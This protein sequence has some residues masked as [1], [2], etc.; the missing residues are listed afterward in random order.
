[1][2]KA[3][4][5]SKDDFDLIG[6]YLTQLQCL[7][8]RWENE[9][10]IKEAFADD[11]IARYDDKILSLRSQALSAARKRQELKQRERRKKAAQSRR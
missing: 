9:G 5:L 7:F 2:Q 1:M 4:P 11:E 6:H 3:E 8:Q 10:A